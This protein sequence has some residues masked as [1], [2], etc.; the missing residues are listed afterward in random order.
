MKRIEHTQGKWVTVDDEDYEHLSNFKWHFA[1]PGYARRHN[2]FGNNCV[3]MHRDI[4]NLKGNEQCDHINGD[5][6]DNRRKNI[7]P[8]RPSENYKNRKVNKNN[9]SG[10]KGVTWHKCANKWQA[11]IMFNG[12]QIYLGK[13]KDL[14]EAANAYKKA[15]KLYYKEFARDL[16]KTS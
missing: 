6:L 7:R 16:C 1:P 2:G 8:C 13:F 4:L 11:M 5:G 12:R 3:L 10:K 9:T 15:E 14:D